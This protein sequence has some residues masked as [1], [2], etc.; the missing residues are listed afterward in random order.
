MAKVYLGNAFSL[1]MLDGDAKLEVRKVSTE[2][3]KK[4]LNGD[5]VSAIGHE[6]TAQ[7]V[8]KLLQTEVPQNRIQLKLEKGDTLVVFQL[9]K[10]LEEGK[11]LSEEELK[12]LPYTWYVVKV[13]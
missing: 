12:S 8:S 1:G 2:D 13:L 4:L 10:R 7:V 3:V 11:V 9:L 6:S 5:F